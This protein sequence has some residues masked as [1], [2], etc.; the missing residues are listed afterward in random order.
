MK[1]YNVEIAHFNNSDQCIGDTVIKFKSRIDAEN[2]V[3]DNG[4]TDS[5][6]HF[7]LDGI[8]SIWNKEYSSGYSRAFIVEHTL[9]DLT[10]VQA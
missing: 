4:Y 5:G 10:Y 2:W 7:T 1:R 8:S 6:E 9:N 3:M